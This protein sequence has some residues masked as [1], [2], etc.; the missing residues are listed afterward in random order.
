VH[1]AAFGVHLA[2]ILF[3]RSVTPAIRK[4]YY[5]N[6]RYNQHEDFSGH[7]TSLLLFVLA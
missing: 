7:T 2:R 5:S 6:Y 4:S 3:I 1:H